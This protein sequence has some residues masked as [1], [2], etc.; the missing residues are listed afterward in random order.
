MSG[1]II[2]E[3]AQFILLKKI[4]EGS[5]TGVGEDAA[6]G[7]K[8]IEGAEEAAKGAEVSYSVDYGLTKE[9]GQVARNTL[10]ELI[11]NYVK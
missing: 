4:G 3:V 11:S 9:S 1:Y 5:V 6:K 10:K 8:G 7:I 2:R